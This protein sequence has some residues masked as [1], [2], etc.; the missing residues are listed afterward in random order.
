MTHRL[1]TL[2]LIL[3]LALCGQA[4]NS[5]DLSGLWSFRIDRQR[6]GE[7]ELWFSGKKAFDDTIL[8]P[9]SM[10]QRLKGDDPSLTTPWTGT[11]YDSSFY[12]NPAMEVYRRTG[13]IKFP[14]FLTP[15]KHY[16]GRAWY[17]RTVNVPRKWMGQR[18]V[19]S[20][21][22]PH[23]QSTLWVN[24]RRVGVQNS[25]SV[26]HVYDVTEYV[27]RGDNTL[28]LCVDNRPETVKVGDDSHSLSDQTQGN[29]NGIVGEM[30]L[31]AMP[32]TYIADLQVYPNVAEKNALVK[33][34]IEAD[35]QAKRLIALSATSFNT[36]LPEQS[37]AVTKEV[38]LSK[39][40]NKVEILLPM[41]DNPYLWDEFSPSLY[42]LNA[43]LA[44]H[45]SKIINHKSTTFGMRD[46]RID[47]KW[48][49]V[50]GHQTMLR[51]TVECCV[52]PLT[53][54]APMEVEEWE[55][56]FRICRQY[57]LNHMRF[58]SYCPPRAAFEA[59]DLVGFYLQPEGPSWPNHGVKLGVGQPI[60]KYLME[61]TIALNR[62]YGNHASFCMLACGNEPAG[63]WVEWVTD[64]VHYWQKAD[65]RHVYTGASV[66]GGWAWQP[67][68]E[69]H[70]KAGAR[71]LEWAKRRP[72]SWS[73]F[74]HKID[75]VSQPFVSHETGQWNCYPNFNEIGKYTGVNKAKN[76]EIFCDLLQ[77]NG[78]G[79][80]GQEFLMASGRLQALCY[81]HELERTLRTPNYAGYQLL[82]LNDYSGQ[83]SAVVGILDA[84]WG[85]K[86]YITAPEWRQFC[87]PTV[88]LAKMDRF[89]FTDRDTIR[90]TI[91]LSHFGETPLTNA[92]FLYIIKDKEGK[93]LHTQQQQVKQVP[94]GG[95]IPLTE[96]KFLGADF[97]DNADK[98]TD[99]NYNK[100][101][102][103]AKSVPKNSSAWQAKQITLEVRLTDC[104]QYRL[105]RTQG[106]G[107]LER[108]YPVHEVVNSWDLWV[109]PQ[110]ELTGYEDPDLM[111][112]DTLSPEAIA[113]LER[114]GKVLLTAAGRVEYGKGIVQHFVPTFWNTSWFKMRPPH[115]VGSWVD[116]A[117]PLFRHFP[118]DSHTG[119]QWWE[120]VNRAQCMMTGHIPGEFRSIVQP[121][122]TWFLSRRLSTLFEA[123][124]GKGRLIMT[125][126]DVRNYLSIRPVAREL[127]HA[128]ITYME[129]DD[130]RPTQTVTVEQIEAIYSRPTPAVDSFTKDSP[131]ELKP[132]IK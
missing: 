96:L 69:F 30:S 89:V 80:Q 88:P 50:N 72:E 22:R 17:Q 103:S 97:A 93:V 71:G 118:T 53:G 130:F 66:G 81:K 111:V 120:L 90:A 105:R 65:P 62:E 70:V 51:G 46:F 86:G 41:G 77:A 27:K 131:D 67:A 5:I 104:D 87:A 54:Y 40:E 114:G 122:D 102:S 42:R 56:V 132:K 16:V 29:W 107:T 75:T 61:E 91:E 83:G 73:T 52:F 119:L 79:H 37:F 1:P 32:K 125:S 2:I 127:M 82:A 110:R 76:F 100:S 15:D 3:C 9:G 24:G 58:H 45:K 109:Y 48:F 101:A 128:L 55:R 47:G 39:G 124:V 121:I 116:A 31:T 35:K 117:H 57:G 63:R 4:Q 64:F 10:P 85:E 68:N 25:L 23:I 28:T 33:L 14:F 49:Y 84:L 99:N 94:I 11:L 98:Y 106:E 112:T 43:E 21:E 6:V 26:P 44:I 129:S 36:P 7:Q 20:L 38:T 19:L 78:M 92:T 113:L 123:R 60:D 18:I 8:L 74:S 34:K 13:N 108:N 12:F 59:A 95:Q 126:F 115:T